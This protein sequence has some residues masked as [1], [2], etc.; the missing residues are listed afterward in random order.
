MKECL[1][2]LKYKK[3]KDFIEISGKDDFNPQHI[4][5]CGQIFSFK[6]N[7]GNYQVFSA[8]KKAEIFET[9]NGY[10]IKTKNPDYF[11]NFFAPAENR[12]TARLFCA[13]SLLPNRQ[14]ECSDAIRLPQLF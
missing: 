7:G 13:V 5:E 2:M 1:R 6:K 11:E 8:D 3:G 9:E 12:T 14:L 4:L 10:I